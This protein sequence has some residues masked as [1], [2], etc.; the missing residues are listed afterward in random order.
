[1]F[2]KRSSRRRKNKTRSEYT[3][4]EEGKSDVLLSDEKSIISVDEPPPA[5]DQYGKGNAPANIEPTESTGTK[6]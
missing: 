2:R 1:M 3:R 5:Y 6:D 4:G